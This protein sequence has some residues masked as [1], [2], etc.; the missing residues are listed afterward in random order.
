MLPGLLAIVVQ[1]AVVLGTPPAMIL[2]RTPVIEVGGN[3][4]WRAR[5]LGDTAIVLVDTGPQT[6]VEID[7]Q[8]GTKRT[9]GGRGAGPGEY[10][11]ATTPLGDSEG[12]LLVSD[13]NLR[14][15]TVYDQKRQILGTYRSQA[16]IG[17]LIYWEKDTLLAVWTDTRT[18]ESTLG[19]IWPSQ[20]GTL[21]MKQT[22][23]MAEVLATGVKRD[24][25]RFVVPAVTYSNSGELYVAETKV[26]RVFRVEGKG[27]GVLVAQREIVLPRLT[28]ERAEQSVEETAR[29][30]G[31][32]DQLTPAVRSAMAQRVMETPQPH[33]PATGLSV[34]GVGRLWVVTMRISPRGTEVDVF[35]RNGTFLG[36]VRLKGTVR[37]LDWR[38]L[39]A[40]A[41]VEERPEEDAHLGVIDFYQAEHR[42][43]ECAR[44]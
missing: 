26:Y 27:A 39:K 12:R 43:G 15:I 42:Q 16:M 13:L 25:A 40:V 20:D 6:V 14:R 3:V 2:Q 29:K 24:P 1:G 5:W 36:T 33:F 23:S 44:R 37:S 41:V 34:D 35:C 28:R 38:G 32:A 10:S 19:K 11:N 31:F 8:T 18:T 21:T 7:V 30:A 9:F 17:M 22:V 4:Q